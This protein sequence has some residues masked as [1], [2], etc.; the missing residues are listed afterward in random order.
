MESQTLHS[1][2]FKQTVNKTGVLLLFLCFSLP[3][4]NLS[5]ERETIVNRTVNHIMHSNYDSAFHAVDSSELSENDPLPLVLKLAIIGM[6]DIDFEKIID[7]TLFLATYAQASEKVTVWEAENDTTS[8]SRMLTGVCGA[9]HASYYLWQKKYFSAMQNGLDALRIMREAQEIDS[10]NH[11][12]DFFLGLYEFARAELRSRLW[13]VLFWYPG[14][15]QDGIERVERS[16]SRAKITASAARLSLCDIYI[17]EKRFED[18]RTAI[19]LLKND[20]PDS[21]FVWWAEVKYFEALDQYDSAEE[22]YYLLAQSYSTE[23]YGEYNYF[24]S[25]S[26]RAEMLFNAGRYETANTLCD[27]MLHKKNINQYSK[28]KKTFKRFWERSGN[29]VKYKKR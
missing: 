17:Q 9:I 13:W 10:T 16:A 7:S 3:A 28:L 21:R 25:S 11:E 14:N 29:A 23:E 8:Y 18:A 22:V 20:Y 1:F 27:N 6:R 26:R 24:Y 12:V 2:L 15:R 5:S 4:F 19:E